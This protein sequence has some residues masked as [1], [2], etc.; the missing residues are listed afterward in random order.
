MSAIR[1]YISST[2][3]ASL[4]GRHDAADDLRPDRMEGV[5]D[6][7][8]DAEVPAAAAQ[9]RREVGFSPALART[10]A[11]STITTSIPTTLSTVQPQ[12]RVK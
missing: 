3:G 10:S 8:D 9:P 2:R 1:R 7:G 5:V 6:A 4:A 12:R 11:P